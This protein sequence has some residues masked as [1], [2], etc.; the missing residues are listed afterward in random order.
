MPRPLRNLCLGAALVAGMAA[1]AHL[2]LP[3]GVP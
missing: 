2:L 3:A 1:L